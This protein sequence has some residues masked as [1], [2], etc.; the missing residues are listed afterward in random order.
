MRFD[1][2]SES[3]NIEDRR[4]N[5]GGL[6]ISGGIGVGTVVLALA[7]W[8][9]GIDPSIVINGSRMLQDGQAQHQAAGPVQ[10]SADEKQSVHLVKVVLHDLEKTWAEQL[11]AQ[12]GKP[13]VNPRL[14]LF[15]GATRTACG[16]GQTAMGPFYCPAD[17]KVYIDLAFYDE[18][19]RR[20]QAPGDFAQAYVIAHEVGHHLQHLL[21]ISD[22][23]HQ[24]QQRASSKAQANALSVR[25]ELQADCFAG[26]WAYHANKERHML[27]AG[28]VD[29]A[30]RAATAIGD[31]ALQQAAQGRVVP[32]SFT[33]GSS[34]QRTRWLQR[35]LQSG[36]LGQC[37][38]FKAE[39]L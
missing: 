18:M 32:D 26:V 37:N 11:P 1:D 4:G 27:E 20:F 15:R 14:V 38:T 25:L 3:S 21:G 6:P 35:G 19:K 39:Q 17:Q 13:Y 22:R 12:T 24:A 30:M 36:E 16:T 23:V 31:D 5:G 2:D 7:A 34:A 8:Y 28:D 33:H 9:F 10:E 29:E